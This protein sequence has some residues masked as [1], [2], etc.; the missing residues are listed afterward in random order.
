MGAARPPL[1]I[2]SA[3]SPAPAAVAQTMYAAPSGWSKPNS[4][5]ATA[6]PNSRCTAPRKNTSSDTA[7]P[8]ASTRI[9]TTPRPGPMP[10]S[11]ASHARRRPRSRKSRRAHGAVTSGS[12]TARPAPALTPASSAPVDGSAAAPRPRPRAALHAAVAAWGAAFG[13]LIGDFFGGLGPGDVFGFLGNLLYGLVPYAIWEALTDVPPVPGGLVVSAGLLAVMAVA[14]TLCA[15]VVG[16][17]LHLLGFHPFTV[18]GTVVLV[19]DL[20][21]AAV[22]APFLLAG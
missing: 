17:G 15:A 3:P 1:A 20:V 6:T 4:T 7:E 5:L 8:S 21:V 18:L 10:D 13:N 19:N 14:S 22:L 16:W 11:S 12:V 2:A 9:S